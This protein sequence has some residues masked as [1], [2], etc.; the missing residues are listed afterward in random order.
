MARRYELTNRQWRLYRRVLP[1]T[2]HHWHKTR[3]PLPHAQRNLKDR[4]EQLRWARRPVASIFGA[5][6]LR[7]YRDHAQTQGNE[8]LYRSILL[9]G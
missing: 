6:D 2:Q 3:Q 1:T 8:R 7:A 5:G 4:H 9:A